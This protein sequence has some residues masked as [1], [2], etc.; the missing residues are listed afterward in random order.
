MRRGGRFPASTWA[1]YTEGRTLPVT[2]GGTGPTQVPS[3]NLQ[4]TCSH[5]CRSWVQK[6][7]KLHSLTEY[8]DF[9]R[10]TTCFSY[11]QCELAS[12]INTYLFVVLKSPRVR[13]LLVVFIRPLSI[14]A[15][16]LSMSGVVQYAPAC[17][18]APMVMLVLCGRAGET[19]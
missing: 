17:K 14:P 12:S 19:H 6:W 10:D 18:A 3:C 2:V 11:Q 4:G 15:N 9:C 5:F 13:G 8:T 1:R 7:I 16:N